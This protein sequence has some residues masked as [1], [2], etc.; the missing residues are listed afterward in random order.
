MI[1]RMMTADHEREARFR[2]AYEQAYG[3]VY[4]YAARRVGVDAADEVTAE[5][6]LVAW[7]R[8]DVM[9]RDQLPW[10]YGVARNVVARYG[11]T[12]TRQERARKA[13]ASERAGSGP[14]ETG[15]PAL[16]S[17]WEQLSASDREVL[18]LIAWE[19]LSVHEAAIAIGC[20]APV[21]SVR[22]HRARKRLERLLTQRTVTDHVSN[23]SEA[24]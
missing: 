12:Q 7:R 2:R 10:L 19:E 11:A 5:V 13:L 1:K 20:S 18:A 24:R 22:L 4:A 17:A 21:F 3:R 15:D 14:S 16:W 6:F 23:P 8:F 9:P